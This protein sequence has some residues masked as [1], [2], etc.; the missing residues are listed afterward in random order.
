MFLIVAT[1]ILSRSKFAQRYNFYCNSLL[2]HAD[3]DCYVF[4]IIPKI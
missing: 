1:A 3:V 4:V 2:L